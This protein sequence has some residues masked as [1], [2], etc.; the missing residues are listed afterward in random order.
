[1]TK[2]Q[3]EAIESLSRFKTIKVLYGKTFVDYQIKTI[4]TK[5]MYEANCYKIPE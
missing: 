1:M 5:E 2:E 3:Q 4:L